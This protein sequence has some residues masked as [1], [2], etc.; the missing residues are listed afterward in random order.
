MHRQSSSPRCFNDLCNF[1]R[2]H[3]VTRATK[4]NLGSYRRRSTGLNYLMNDL[5]HLLWLAKQIGSTFI[6]LGYLPDRATEIDVNYADT[7]FF[8]QAPPHLC[9]RLRLVI[10]NLHRQWLRF[11]GNTPQTIRMLRLVLVHP[12]KA[13]CI[14][15]LSRLQSRAAVFTDHLSKRIIRK[16]SHGCLQNRRIDRDRT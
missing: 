4:S 13:A 6:A 16:P 8:N 11:I 7:V 5:S 14:D 2:I 3:V 10:P 9:Q 15:H 1:N 12:H